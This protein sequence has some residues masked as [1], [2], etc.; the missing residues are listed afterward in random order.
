MVSWLIWLA[1]ILFAGYAYLFLRG[2]GFVRRTGV[3]LHA[4][5]EVLTQ[6]GEAPFIDSFVPFLGHTLSMSKNP[7]VFM[8][9]AIKKTKSK[10]FAF[11][12]AGR[13]LTMIAVCV[14]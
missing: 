8:N 11:P 2:R 4:K 3:V 14:F 9:N 7:I 10:V 5:E 6:L 12:F 13:V 1:A